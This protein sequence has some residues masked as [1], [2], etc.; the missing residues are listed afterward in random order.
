MLQTYKKKSNEYNT[1]EMLMM[2]Q[3][4]KCILLTIIN[5]KFVVFLFII[6]ITK[7]SFIY[8][9]DKCAHKVRSVYI[10]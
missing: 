3:N 8:F 6:H 7:I 4:S 5:I 10:D 9:N 1:I 2:M